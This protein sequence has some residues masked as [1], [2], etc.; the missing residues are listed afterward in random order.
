MSQPAPIEFSVVADETERLDKFLAD[1]LGGQS[2]SQIQRLIE[3][4]HVSLPRLKTVKAN[5][6][7]RDGDVMLFRFSS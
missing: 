2:R 3:D 7:V 5:T 1:Q 4:G 6:V